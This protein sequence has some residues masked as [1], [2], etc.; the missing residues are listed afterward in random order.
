MLFAI[1]KQQQHLAELGLPCRCPLFY[2]DSRIQTFCRTT[3]MNSLRQNFFG[4][5]IY[6]QGHKSLGSTCTCGKPTNSHYLSHHYFST[7]SR[8]ELRL[9]SG[10]VGNVESSF[11]ISFL[12]S[13]NFSLCEFG[14]F[15]NFEHRL[16]TTLTSGYNLRFQWRFF[17]E[18]SCNSGIQNREK[19]RE[20]GRLRRW[21][22]NRFE[23]VRIIRRKMVGKQIKRA[24]VRIEELPA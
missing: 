1:R 24:K 3:Q 6:C 21:W 16:S 22:W 2:L 17:Q 19:Y 5:V 13:S 23:F 4:L 8:Q 10:S 15:W 7:I 9:G 20:K 14:C 12:T 11:T 18:T